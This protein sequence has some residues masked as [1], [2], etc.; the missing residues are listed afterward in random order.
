MVATMVTSPPRPP[1][2][3]LG[4]PRGTYFSR[5]KAK[6]PLP[7][8]PALTRMVTSS[9]NTEGTAEAELIRCADG[10][11]LPLPATIAVFNGAGNF[12]EQSIVLAHADV[13]AGLVDAAALA[14]DD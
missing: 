6:Q 14:H 11:E 7:P 8:L 1:S 10:D 3:P 9:M 13:L 12:G 4:P 2:P 5:R